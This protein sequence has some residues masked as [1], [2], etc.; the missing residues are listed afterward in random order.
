MFKNYK[1]DIRITITIAG[2][3]IGCGVEPENKLIPD[4][5]RLINR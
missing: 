3:F 2:N 4:I 1:E 5:V